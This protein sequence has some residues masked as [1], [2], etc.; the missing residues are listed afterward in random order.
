[1]LTRAYT[2]GAAAWQWVIFSVLQSFNLY[3]IVTHAMWRDELQVW[4]I[5][6]ESRTITELFSNMRYDGFPALWYVFLWGLS[7]IS[8]SPLVMQLFHFVCSFAAQL[9]VMTRSPFSGRMKLAILAGYYISFEYCV[10]SRAYVLGVLFL[11]MFCA[12]YE[13]LSEHPAVKGGI[14]GLLANTSIYGAM[15]SLVFAGDAVYDALNK[16]RSAAGGGHKIAGFA[17]VYGALLITSAVVILPPDDGTYAA[18]LVLNTDISFKFYLF[19]RNLISLI[20]I[21]VMKTAFWNSLLFIDAGF[22]PTVAT[23]MFVLLAVWFALRS[24]PRHLGIFA[25]GFICIW[26]FSVIKYEGALRHVGALLLLFIACIWLAAESVR[27]KG[28][29]VS[30]YSQI[31]VGFIVTA[32]IIAFATA[33]YYHLIYDFSGSREMTDIIRK[34]DSAVPVV[35]DADYAASSVAGYLGRPLYYARNHKAQTFIRWNRERMSVSQTDITDMA[36]DLA[37]GSGGGRALILLNYPM[38]PEQAGFLARTRDS[39]V[40]DEVF[41]L[42]EYDAYKK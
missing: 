42:Y 20:P 31:A 9:L 3:Q 10:I 32:N 2:K 41:Y 4:S 24:S 39:I 30:R 8:S 14:L 28:M 33:S 38:E 36:R 34:F 37:S 11:F 21:P 22:W 5:V 18:G 35:A 16:K 25:A 13:W 15:V 1:M 27:I 40:D 7:F 29:P 12:F 26:V 19:C 17:A 23:S 6:R